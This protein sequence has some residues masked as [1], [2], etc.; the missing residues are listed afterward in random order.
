MRKSNYRLRLAPP[1]ALLMGAL[2]I[3]LI[4]LCL[5]TSAQRNPE[6]GLP[7]ITNYQAKDYN[8]SPQNWSIVEAD[9]GLMYFGNSLCLLEYDGVKWRRISNAIVRAMAKDGQ[10]RI[11]YGA[12]GDFG[13]LAT[14]SLGQAQLHSLISFVPKALHDF[15]DVWSVYAGEDGI[16]FQA[17]ERVFRLREITPNRWQ[18]KAWQPSTKYMYAFYLDG[19]YYVH[20]QNVG[21]LKLTGDRLELIPGSEFLG[22]ERTQVML[23][24]P[25]PGGGKHYLIGQFYSGLYHFDGKTFQRFPTEADPYIVNNTLYKAAVLKDGTYALSSTGAGLVV[26]D[27]QGKIRQRLNRDVG[28]Q[29]ESVYGVYT[30]SKGALW[31][32]LD[33]GISKVQ[34]ASPF[35]QFAIES[36][37]TSAALSA[38]RFDGRLYLGTTNGLLIFN[39][40]TARFEPVL[41]VPRTQT[42]NLLPDGKTLLVSSD[43]LYGISG[44]K[45]R[46]IEPSEG[47]NVQIQ[48]MLISRQYPNVMLSTLSGGMGLFTKKTGSAEWQLAGRIPGISDDV[49]TII[50]AAGGVFW[51]GTQDNGALRL[52]LRRDEQGQPLVEQTIVERFGSNHGLPP[53]SVSVMK[54]G[55]VSYFGTKQGLYRFDERTHRFVKDS[56]FGE[57]HFGDDVNEY[58]MTTD[59][60]GRIWLSMEK[61]ITLATPKPG[62]GYTLQKVPFLPIADLSIGMIYPEADGTVWFCTTEGLVRY[63]EKLSKNYDEPYKTVLRHVTAGKKAL[64]PQYAAGDGSQPSLSYTNNTLR[65]D[66]AAPFFEQEHKTEYQTWLEGF[67][68]TWSDWDI[69]HYKEYTNLS[70]GDYR[71]HVRAKN[72]Y[73]KVSEEAVYA[74]GVLPP[75]YR[76]WWAYALYALL[77]AAVIYAIV[78]YRTHQLHEKH[79]ELEHTVADRTSEL[80]QRVAELEVINVVQEGL[81]REM[82]IDAIY[83]LMGNKIREVFDAQ[84]VVIATFDHKAGT[85][86]F[87]YLIEKGIRYY[88]EPRPLDNLRQHLIQTRQKVLINEN[89]EEVARQYGLH[90]VPNTEF[91]KSLLFVPLV[92]GDKITSYVSLQNIDREHAFNTSDVRLL[93]TLANSMSVA[94]ENARLFD[95]INRLLKETEQRN[96]ELAVINSVQESLVA[97]MNIQAIY[98]LVG[99]KIR[100]IF[101]AQV[102]DI[103]T[104]DKARNIIEDRYAYEKGDRTLVGPREPNGFRKHVIQTK[105]VLL[106]NE[107]IEQIAKEYNNVILFGAMPKSM[108]L[109]PMIAG[110]EVTGIISLQD[111]DKEHAISQ[112]DVN[113]LTTLANSMSVALE[114]ARLFDE[115][116]VLLKETEQRNAELA[117]INSVQEGL[118]REMNIQGI[119]DLVG[120]KI[121]QI[122]NTQVV[123]IVTYDRTK[124]LIEDRYAFENG[125]RTLVGPREPKGFRKH[126]LDTGQLL[127]FN[128]DV[129]LHRAE[130]DNTV[131]IGEGAKSVL[132][133]PMIANNKT[134]GVISLQNSFEENAFS[135]SDVKLLTTLANSMSVALEGVRLFDE[136]KLLL[137]E[138]EKGKRNIELLSEIG[139]QITASLDFETI[140]YKLYEHINQLA[141]ATVFGIGLYDAEQE[142]IDY[143][144]AVERGKRYEPYTRDTKDK[145]QFPVWCIEHRQPVFINDVAQEYSRYI[146]HFKDKELLLEDGTVSQDPHSLIYLPLMVQEKV[147]GIITIQSF[148]KNAYSEYHLNLLQNLATYTSIALDN[149]N[150]YRQLNVREQE[151]GR[152]AAELSTVNNISQA[153]ASQLNLKELI[154]L[155]GDQMRYLF[156]ANIV[157]LAMLDKKTRTITFPYQFGDNLP[158]MKLGDGLTSQILLT[159]AP[160]LI[161]KEVKSRTEEL[162][163]EH[164]GIPAASYLGV[165]IPVGDEVIGVLSV[166]ST[167]EENRFDERDQGLL[168]TIAASVGVAIRKAKLFEEVKQARQEA[169]AARKTA[170]QAN[171]AK[172]AFLSTVSHEL[173]TPLTS[174]LGFAKIIRK[175]L[176]EKIF[177]ATDQTDPKTGK[178]IQ[179]VTENLGVVIAEGERLTHLINDVLDLAKIEA[180]KMEWNMTTVSITEV[181]E[182]AI[183]ATTALFYQKNIPLEREFELDLPDITGDRDKL[184]QV[185]VNLLSNAVKFTEQGSVTCRA[186]RRNGEV[187]VSVADTG[188][189]IAT[190]DHAAVFEQFKQVGDTLTDKPKG[191]GL[192]LPISKEIVEHH[193]G[194]IWLESEVSRGST[195]SFA[196][197]VGKTVVGKPLQLDDLVRRLKEQMAQSHFNI[198]GNSTILIVDDEEAIRSLLRQ[199]LTEA[200]YLVEEAANGREALE[201]VRT[202]KPDLIILDIMM[203][204]IN[205]F[206]VA[207]ILK[208]DPQ[209]MDIPIIVLSIVQDKSRGYRIGV[210]R[211]LTKPIDTSLL[212]SEVGYLLEQGKS[213]KKVMVVDEDSVTVSTL[214]DV[215]EAKGYQ[216]VESDG[217]ELV[218]KAIATQPD[219]II[220][221]SVFNAREE[222]VQSLRFEKGLE[223]VL[224]LIYQSAPVSD[225]TVK[226]NGA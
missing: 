197:P 27:T 12:Y 184:I 113:L 211:Y 150:A 83:D 34:T 63:D 118:V 79:R 148:E 140:F 163:I 45:P 182:R 47:G 74:F 205:G 212:F 23:P 172:S 185:V 10:G 14:D 219:I 18:V 156:K 36:G 192:G 207:A 196:L 181:V 153:L 213:K 48:T 35:T 87:K 164:I 133:V 91:P 218:E 112:S 66:Y 84:T 191:T 62:G 107:N 177:P 223:N 127:L 160:L 209:T 64:S 60:K 1:A 15:N 71:F 26:I 86:H 6:K 226:N 200:G 67:E 122:F 44:G 165:P 198:K 2:W 130:Y 154:D 203:P 31:L 217:K 142:V 68:P 88:P 208:N 162:G 116:K 82:D 90:V 183:A 25:A 89:S 190:E 7:F 115:T 28:L 65:F 30:D 17:R 24:Y 121:R 54:A 141:D 72:I 101:N 158:P 108:A 8:A 134:T 202:N 224:F 225:S 53:G 103:V 94:L 204:E 222:A 111:L 176:E 220:L 199:E 138:T 123:D 80:S 55:G 78:R 145:N 38:V 216:V 174:V 92:L 43:G 170:E 93:E 120:E 69:N 137:A 104:Y 81:V 188:I 46:V 173:R 114:S 143:K 4:H 180:G 168:S 166:Q 42:F 215:L 110:G 193:G 105:Q 171:E 186:F 75:W 49:W 195:F 99:E 102:I 21:L 214:T 129:P 22:K 189:G 221:N 179:Q 96:A 135:E 16:Y 13:Y 169:E 210:D 56:T 20:E 57:L 126:V 11:Y 152:R 77:G 136:T 5:H 117:V 9:N 39:E 97:Q 132:F 109:V 128:E 50:E 201:L 85:E 147:L 59:A 146:P 52:R 178:T 155:V 19:S 159:G 98:D 151:I 187:V 70:G 51:A 41:S 106:I 131:M 161:N 139:K 73:G 58:A 3:V 33:N 149:A 32:G 37:V 95:Q 124:N 40:A 194:R 144:F 100:E 29:D 175:R 119:Y 61:G 125:D 206:D 157:Y 76:T 167:V